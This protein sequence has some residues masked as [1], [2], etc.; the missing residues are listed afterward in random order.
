MLLCVRGEG[1]EGASCSRAGPCYTCG[2]TSTPSLWPWWPANRLPIELRLPLKLLP[3]MLPRRMTKSWLRSPPRAA[4]EPSITCC[5]LRK[6]AAWG[7]GMKGLG[8]VSHLCLGEG[9]LCDD[10]LALPVN[11]QQLR[12][13]QTGDN[14]P[15]HTDRKT[16]NFSSCTNLKTSPHSGSNRFCTLRISKCLQGVELRSALESS[17]VTL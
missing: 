8:S 9:G 6:G 10:T 5:T 14:T 15:Q 3:V 1:G 16:F 11:E 4:G 12:V 2:V 13:T 17:D 7:P